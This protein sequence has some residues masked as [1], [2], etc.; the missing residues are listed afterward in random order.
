MDE[1]SRTSV[2]SPGP[3]IVPY[4]FDLHDQ[5]YRRPINPPYVISFQPSDPQHAKIQGFP[6]EGPPCTGV[7]CTPRIWQSQWGQELLCQA[8]AINT[9]LL[10]KK[11]GPSFFL[12]IY[13]NS[14]NLFNLFF[15]QNQFF[16]IKNHK[17]KFHKFR[18]RFFYYYF[19]LSNLI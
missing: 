5:V 15:K 7:K 9:P 11:P 17:I 4:Y 1:G 16:S 13:F 3:H 10:A 8:I 19:I 14:F 18:I 2:R 12:F 6:H